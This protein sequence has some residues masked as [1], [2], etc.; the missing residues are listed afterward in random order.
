M[1]GGTLVS[2]IIVDD[3]EDEDNVEEEERDGVTAEMTEP[4]AG[5]PNEP[6]T[7]VRFFFFLSSPIGQSCNVN[8]FR[9]STN[10]IVGS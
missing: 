9:Q 1:A 7:P 4:G 2:S 3:D 6:S 8:R 5:M 10:H